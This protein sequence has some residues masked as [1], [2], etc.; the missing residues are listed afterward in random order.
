MNTNR[1]IKS[2]LTLPTC[3]VTSPTGGTV[4]H[5][6]FSTSSSGSSAGSSGSSSGSGGSSAGIRTTNGG[7]TSAALAAAG[8]LLAGGLALLA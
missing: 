2:G 5:L 4:A 1:T 6:Q 8:T 7:L 3:E